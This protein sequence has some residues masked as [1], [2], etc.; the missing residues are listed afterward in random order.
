MNWWDAF[1]GAAYSF[2][3]GGIPSSPQNAEAELQAGNPVSAFL[4]STA[5]AIGRGL[6]SGIIAILKDIWDVILGPLEIIAG[7]VLVIMAFMLMFRRDLMSI[8]RLIA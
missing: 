6:E 4:S 1:T 3:H 7:A 8:A 5:G 2:F